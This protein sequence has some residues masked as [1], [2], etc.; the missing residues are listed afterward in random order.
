MKKIFVSNLP[1]SVR[2]EQLAE[3]F[4]DFGPIESAV[5]IM[6]RETG[7]SKGFGF[8]EIVDDAKAEEAIAKLNGADYQGRNLNVNEAR[9]KEDRPRRDFNGGGNRDGGSFRQGNRF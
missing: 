8:V 1:Y 6:E 3:I 2:D 5:V 4:A 9:P 7:R